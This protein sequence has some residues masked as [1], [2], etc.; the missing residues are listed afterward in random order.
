MK[1]LPTRIEDF[2]KL[3]CDNNVDEK[4]Y[5]KNNPILQQRIS[6]NTFII[7]YD[8]FINRVDNQTKKQNGEYINKIKRNKGKVIWLMPDWFDKSNYIHIKKFLKDCS[9]MNVEIENPL[10]EVY[11]KLRCCELWQ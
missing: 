8:T 5:D 7:N 3:C 10:C 1:D 9:Y 4:W 2:V 11:L 6:G